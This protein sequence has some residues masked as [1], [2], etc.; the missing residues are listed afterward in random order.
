MKSKSKSRLFVKN[1]N[2]KNIAIPF[3][4]ILTFLLV[5]FNKTDY[6]LVNKMKTTSIDVVNP[7]SKVIFYP[8]KLSINT[9]DLINDLRLAEKE[10]IKLKEEVIRLKKWQRLA[11]INITENKAYKK[12]LNSTSNSVNIIKTASI[13]NHSPKIYTRSVLINAGYNHNIEKN[14]VAINERGLVG[15]V[16]FVTKNNSKILLINDQNSSVPVQSVRGNFFAIMKGSSDGKYLESSFIKDNKKPLVGDIL[17]TSGRANI[18][19]YNILVGK[20]IKILDEKII[21]LPFVDTKNLEFLQI[22]KN[23]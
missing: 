1:K 14:F 13:I 11:L 2:I 22:V 20:V 4:F 19:P 8:I 3:L 6:F 9:I 5:L 18:Y 17:V 15:K 12:L 21:A 10:N 16:I 23:N 7:I